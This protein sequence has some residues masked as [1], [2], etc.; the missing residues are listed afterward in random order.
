MIKH[1]KRVQIPNPHRG[2][3]DW[4]LVSRLL[5]QAEIDPEQWKKLGN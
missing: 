5:K 4:S 1:G 3:L 2:D